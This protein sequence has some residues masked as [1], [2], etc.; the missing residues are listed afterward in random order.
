[1]NHTVIGEAGELV[2]LIRSTWQIIG[3]Y[4][5]PLFHLYNNLYNHKIPKNQNLLEMQQK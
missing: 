3:K 4:K 2:L 1:M 5:M